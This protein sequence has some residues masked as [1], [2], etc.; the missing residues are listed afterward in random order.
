M[1][2]PIGS[3]LAASLRRTY[4]HADPRSLGL[5]RIVYGA[6]LLLTL[7]WRFDALESFYTNQGLMPNHTML[8]AAPS[9]HMFSLFFTASSAAEARVGMW[10]C[11]VVF[12]SLL[13]GYRTRLCQV[14][15]LICLVSINSRQLL[16]ETGGDMVLNLLGVWT[17]W[18]PL[19][20]RFSIDARLAAVRGGTPRPPTTAPVVSLAML[21]LILQFGIA[22]LFNVLHKSGASWR[23]GTSV[24]L[25]LHQDRIATAFA[26][27]ARDLPFGV[28]QFASYATLVI[29]AVGCALILSPIATYYTRLVAV[30]MMPFL[31]L[32]FAACLNLGPFSYAMCAFFPLLLQPEHWARLERNPRLAAWLGLRAASPATLHPEAMPLTHATSPARLGLTK[33]GRALAEAYVVLMMVACTGEIMQ[34]NPVVPRWLRYK[35]PELLQALIEYPRLLQ[36]WRM[37]APDAPTEDSWLTV[38]AR[39]VDGRLVDPYNEVATRYRTPPYDRIP[40][41]LGMDQF[42]T[43]H[44]L[45]MP[46]GRFGP[47]RNAFK[48]WI[49]AYPQR[50]GRP[51]DRIVSFV[52]YQ[53]IDQSP[54]PGQ[55]QPR[56]FRKHAF[57]TH[58]EGRPPPPRRR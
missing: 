29:E 58:P 42:F 46:S 1:P 38:E 57:M 50:T 39:T 3:R 28:L 21:A 33:L 17:L 8:W 5:F 44:S 11:G 45:F 26:V 40:P 23:D 37:F 30:F 48:D 16:L 7:S 6:V 22:Y 47:F 32:C 4:L 56:N 24:H 25:V 55:T 31:H 12:T 49:L 34:A 2:R 53:L 9:R 14:L 19:G 52:A 18:L 43:S 51:Q 27:W 10:I 35:Q 41:R 36:G 54:P 15:S 20:Q 13:L